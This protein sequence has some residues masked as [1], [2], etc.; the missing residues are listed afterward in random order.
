MIRITFLGTAASRPTVGR[1]VSGIAV[2]RGGDHFLFD[3]GE[4]TQ[5]QMMRFGTGFSIK[6]I[7]I[8]HLHADHFLGITGLLRTMALQGRTEPIVIFGPAGSENILHD[9]VS[10]GVERERFPVEII[11]K[12]PGEALKQQDYRI[13]A[14]PVNHGTNAVGWALLEDERLGR[15]NIE[16]ARDIGI[17]EGPLFGQLHRGEDVE[18]D[19]RLVRAKDLVGQTRPGRKVVYTG[20][21]SPCKMTVDQARGAD[22]LIH[23]ATFGNEEQERARQTSHS[24]AAEA[25]AI[26]ESCDVRRLVLTHLSARYSEDPRIL[27][28]EATAIFRE[29]RIAHD[30]LSI[31]V[32]HHDHSLA[33]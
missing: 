2:Q 22:L 10:L 18:I 24:T 20:D 30:G 7:F 29:S 15:F 6:W 27:K 3:C 8:T 1:N 31:E 11:G 17:P 14:F 23:E 9:A 16:R 5:R 28:E 33:D 26:A 4:G 12:S 21:T 25:A 32:D 19:G 13:Q